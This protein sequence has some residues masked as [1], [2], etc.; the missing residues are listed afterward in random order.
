M[1]AVAKTTNVGRSQSTKGLVE[2]I[3][4][5]GFTRMHFVSMGPS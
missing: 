3:A 2:Q 5:T 1:N 4:R